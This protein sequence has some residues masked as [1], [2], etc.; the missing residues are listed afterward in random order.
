MSALGPEIKHNP[1]ARSRATARKHGT[2]FILQI[3]A[4]DTTALRTSLNSY[5]RWI[6]AALNV[7]NLLTLRQ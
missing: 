5:L 4:K 6:N 3:E 2:T 7:L 1:Y